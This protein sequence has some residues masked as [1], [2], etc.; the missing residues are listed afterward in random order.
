MRFLLAD[1]K[2]GFWAN[3]FKYVLLC[4]C[5]L[6][7]S[8]QF[9]DAYHNANAALSGALVSPPEQRPFTVGDMYLS[10]FI[11][12]PPPLTSGNPLASFPLGWFT[13]QMVVAAIVGYYPVRCG[14]YDSQ[15]YLRTGSR[16]RA[17][18]S[19][20]IWAILAVLASYL[21]AFLT[22]FVTALVAGSSSFTL[23]PPII[24]ALYPVDISALTGINGAALLC[25]PLTASLAVSAAQLAI[26]RATSPVTG[27]IFMAAYD[28]ISVF[29]YAIPF[30]PGVSM[31]A[32]SAGRDGAD[33]SPEAV[34]AACLTCFII[35]AA[36]FVTTGKHADLLNPSEES[37]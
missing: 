31:L 20:F 17:S 32:R 34:L 8:L 18:L 10:Y 25:L 27:V 36:V 15:L 5:F 22:C 33:V 28:V 21:L 24:A 35:G 37:E 12:S 2:A 14:Y 23:S 13:F 6:L 1:I 29:V 16:L 11:G 7:M 9:L 26:A 4:L 19:R 3:R 30:L